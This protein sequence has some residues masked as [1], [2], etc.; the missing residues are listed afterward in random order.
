VNAEVVSDAKLQ[1]DDWR[2]AAKAL[3]PAVEARVVI[4]TPDFAKKPL[5]LYAGA[6][7]ALPPEG[8]AVTEVVAIGNARPPSFNP[9]PIAPSGIG[10][11]SGDFQEV[12]RVASPSYILIRFRSPQPAQVTPQTLDGTRFGRKPA[13]ILLQTPKGPAQ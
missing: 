10:I 11:V 1:R 2:G 4:V 8:A 9:Y 12:E 13:A 3:G 7:R 6:M 5:Q